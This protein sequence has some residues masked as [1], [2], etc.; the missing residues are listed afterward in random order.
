MTTA[1]PKKGPSALNM[2]R[3]LGEEVS[4]DMESSDCLV[5]QQADGE[6]DH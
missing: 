5:T 3:A 6:F 1:I 2:R 4:D